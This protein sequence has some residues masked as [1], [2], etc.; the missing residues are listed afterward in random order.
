MSRSQDPQ[1]TP[2]QQR[3]V[4]R[5]VAVLAVVAALVYAVFIVKGMPG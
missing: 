2:Q 4:R 5:T 1:R 3:G